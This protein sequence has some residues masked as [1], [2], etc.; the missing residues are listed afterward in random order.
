M[1]EITTIAYKVK[2]KIELNRSYMP[3][4][5]DGG[6]LFIPTS[7]TF[8]LGEKI[9]VNLQLPDHA[10]SF[11]VEGK[12]IWITP[13]RPLHLA[14]PGI[15]IQFISDNA[16]TVLNYIHNALDANLEIGGYTYWLEDDMKK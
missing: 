5:K 13:T 8:S 1:P 16:K 7:K 4:I 2:D 9:Q 11:N 10:E 6:G 12:V 14:L 3:F 15:G